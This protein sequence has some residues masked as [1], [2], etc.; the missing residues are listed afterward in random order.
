M[1]LEDTK[2]QDTQVREPAELKAQFSASY[3]NIEQNLLLS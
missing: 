3:V 1:Q 2:T